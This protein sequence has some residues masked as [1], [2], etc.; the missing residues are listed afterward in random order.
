MIRFISMRRPCLGLAACLAFLPAVPA[1][2]TVTIVGTQHLRGLD[3]PPTPEQY[4][5]TIDALSAFAPT[6]VCIER[7]SGERLQIKA[8]DPMRNAM[9]L[10]PETHSRPLG[11]LIIPL[12]VNMQGRLAVLPADA[13][14][15]A[16]DLAARWD[17]LSAQ[18]RVRLIGLQIAGYEFHSAVLD[19]SYLDAEARET[20]AE[21]V[22]EPAA[23]ALEE[24]IHLNSEAY[25]LAVPIARRAGLHELCTADSLKDEAAGMQVALA[26]GGQEILDGPEVRARLETYQARISASWRP[27][28]GPEALTRMLAFMNS[29]AFAEFDRDLQWETLRIHDN[30]AGAFHRRLMHWH[31]RTAQI[32]SELYRALAKGPEERV[33]LIIGAAHRPFNEAEMRAQ[34]WLTVEPASGLLEAEQGPGLCF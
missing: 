15:Q 14:E 13:R 30:E 2:Q 27:D 20:A 3:I 4:A 23:E 16:R 22:L 9:A 11:T 1:A 34:P 17:E 32:S 12:G 5:H 29:D 21:G 26:R 8:A 24:M 28:S 19:W 33:V 31:A 18:E 10:S 25:A 7:M 6:Q